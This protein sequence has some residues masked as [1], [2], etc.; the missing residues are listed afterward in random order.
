MCPVC[1]ANHRGHFGS[2]G[3]SACFTHHKII[4]S[5]P[6]VCVKSRGNRD[7]GIEQ[8]VPTVYLNPLT[9]CRSVNIAFDLS[10]PYRRTVQSPA[11]EWTRNIR[12]LVSCL[13]T[14]SKFLW[15]EIQEEPVR[16][17]VDFCALIGLLTVIHLLDRFRRCQYGRKL[18]SPAALAHRK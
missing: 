11:L 17:V 7:S 18:P 15:A 8:N 2:V 1:R 10:H 4:L 14:A 16:F 13:H 5:H 6:I 3:G 9:K 12:D